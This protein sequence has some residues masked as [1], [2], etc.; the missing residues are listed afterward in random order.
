MLD[1]YRNSTITLEGKSLSGNKTEIIYSNNMHGNASNAAIVSP[2]LFV[3]QGRSIFE[4]RLGGRQSVGR[5]TEDSAPSIPIDS[6]FVSREH[7]VFQTYGEFTAFTPAKTTNGIFYKGKALEPGVDKIMKDGDELMIPTDDG[8]DSDSKY[9]LLVYASTSTRIN[10]WRGFQLATADELTGLSGRG[11]FVSWWQRNQNKGDYTKAVV[12]LL[13]IDD[14]KN[15]NDSYGH[16]VG[17]KVLKSVA[18]ALKREVRYEN[19]VCRWG[20]DEFAGIIPGDQYKAEFRLKQL[21]MNIEGMKI[22]GCPPI[23]VSI[24]YA[25]IRDAKDPLNMEELIQMADKALYYVKQNG[26]QDICSY[27]TATMGVK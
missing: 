14:F 10:M 20:G 7:G 26:K 23:S 18:L 27:S 21:F 6:R 17:D 5:P 1:S 3:S 12:F 24:G 9:I 22:D 8:L 2:R 11:S 13:D 19:Q 16:N 25:D 4:Y 15:I